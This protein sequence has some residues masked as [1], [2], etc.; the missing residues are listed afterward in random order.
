MSNLQNAF[1]EKSDH[2]LKS[3]RNEEKKALE[4]LK[5]VGELRFDKSIEL[6][7]FRHDLYDVRPSQ[8]IDDHGYAKNYVNKPITLDISLEL[9]NE[10][11][12]IEL[13]APA[14]I[15]LGMLASEWIAETDQW[16]SMRDFVANKLDHFI[17]DDKDGISPKDVVLYGFG[18]I[19]RLLARRLISITGKG[20]QLRLRAIVVRQKISDRKL[21]TD[22]RMSLLKSDSVHGDF[23]GKIEISN[24]GT[25]AI[26]NGNRVQIIYAQQPEDID[27]TEYGISD[28]LILDNTGVWRDKEGLSRHLRPGISQVILTAPGKGVPNIVH[29]V[30][31]KILDQS[32]ENLI[33]AASCTTNAIVPVIKAIEDEIG[34]DRAHIETIHAYTSDQNLLDNFHKKERRG[35]AAAINMVLTSTGAGNAVVKVFPHL[36]G[37]ITGNAVRVPTPDVSLAILSVGLSRPSSVDEINAMMKNASLYGDLVEQVAYSES[38]E[39]VSNHVVG[40]TSACVIDAPSTLISEDGRSV[41]IYAWYDNEF[42]YCCQV[43]RLAK[44]FAKVR[45]YAYY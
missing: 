32:D 16:D 25:E 11:N 21:E 24:D 10:I 38:T 31:H 7:L 26:I 28:A 4:L 5:I 12:N 40:T 30:N 13:L 43:V 18:R 17:G 33:S 45:R 19:G 42:G 8:V 41:N 35:R 23:P 15:D 20:E 2:T 27:Y 29:G 22:K 14:K 3:W 37:K 34:I 6:V 39:Y 1:T 36:K 44:Y 9:A